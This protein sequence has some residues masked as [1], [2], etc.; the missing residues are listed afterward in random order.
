VWGSRLLLP[1]ERA[2]KAGADGVPD[3]AGTIGRS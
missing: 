1:I 3:W 2:G